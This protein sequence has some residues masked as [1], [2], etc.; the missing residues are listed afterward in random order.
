MSTEHLFNIH[1]GQVKLGKNSD[2]L[3]AT[4]GSC[5]GIALIWRE[6]KLC[7]LA[8]CLLP[9]SHKKTSF[10]I[11]ARTVTEAIPS[12]IALMKIRPEDR[13]NIEAIVVGGGNMTGNKAPN[14]LL[15]GH[16][17]VDTALKLLAQ[18][19]IKVIHQDTGGNEGRTIN[20]NCA[21]FSFQI[22]KI[23]KITT[24]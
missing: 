17:N 10:T 18:N 8:H 23:P 22:R 13:E 5:V 19:Y 11:S 1:I 9:E 20:L 3:K 14:S 21:D 7:A 12:M 4:L 16:Y 24:R 2:I 15:I 6:K